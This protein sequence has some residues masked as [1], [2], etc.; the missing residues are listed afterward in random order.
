MTAPPSPPPPPPP[1]APLPPRPPGPPG[2]PPGLRRTLRRDR[3]NGMLGGVCAGIAETYGFDVTLVRVLWV[4]AGVLWIGVPAYL[5]AWVLLPRADGPIERH[6]RRH[7][8]GMLAGLAL[9]TIGVVIAS[10]RL[11]PHGFRF[12]HF[13]A[14]LLLIGGGLAILFLRGRGDDGD[15]HDDSEP[16]ASAPS[17]PSS[18]PYATTTARAPSTTDVD[19][20]PTDTTAVPP[21]A[22]TQT[23]T[24]PTPPSARSIRRAYRERRARRPRS[25]LTPVTLSL[26]LIGAGIASLLQATGAADV[27]LTV[28]L[29]I[30]TCV[31]G[32]ALVTA[33]FAG[34][35]HTLIL[36]GLVLL[37]A[38]AIS[39]TIDV[40][41]RGGIG[42]HEYRPVR[43]SELRTHYETGIGKLVLDLRDLPLADRTTTVTA[44][45]GVGEVLVDVPSAVRVEVHAHAGAGAVTLFNND[46][47]GG[48][49]ENDQRA[50]GGSGSGLLRL[51]LRVGAGQIRV[52]RFEPGGIETI[53]GGN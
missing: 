42:D 4:V 32:V 9:L 5:V 49:P 6:S 36:V 46:T 10:N 27:N 26:L 47:H 12:D 43:L 7:D 41:L 20:A 3:A 2:P 31:V 30:G 35:A 45:A 48:W 51:D 19:E 44:Q 40:P 8:P 39:N 13:G 22:W 16:E 17:E 25:F 29:A 52:R 15:P 21:T 1:G 18:S 14:P 50:V 37:G 24:W 38:T 11:L 23:T 33:A 28:V 34:R 53:V